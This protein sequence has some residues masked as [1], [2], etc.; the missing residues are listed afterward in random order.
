VFAY[1][2][3]LVVMSRKKYRLYAEAFG[4]CFVYRYLDL[5]FR[6]DKSASISLTCSNNS[7]SSFELNEFIVQNKPI[8]P[9]DRENP[10]K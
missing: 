2:D 3:D 8:P 6:A 7:Q 9:L 1:A 10:Y 4:R 5:S